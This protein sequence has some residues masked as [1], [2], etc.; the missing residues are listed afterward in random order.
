MFDTL[1]SV[2]TIALLVWLVHIIARI[3]RTVEELLRR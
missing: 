2:L 3:T 1:I